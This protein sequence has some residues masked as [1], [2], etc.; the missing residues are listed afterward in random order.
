M[1][2]SSPPLAYLSLVQGYFDFVGLIFASII[3][4]WIQYQRLGLKRITPN[5]LPTIRSDDEPDLSHHL[6]RETRER[7]PNAIKNVWRMAQAKGPGKVI[8]LANGDFIYLFRF[9]LVGMGH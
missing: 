3:T 1:A 9:S 7:K 5:S 8:T 6:C 4:A 2:L